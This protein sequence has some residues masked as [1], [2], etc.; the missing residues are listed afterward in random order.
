MTNYTEL[1]QRYLLMLVP[2]NGDEQQ[3]ITKTLQFTNSQREVMGI[4]FGKATPVP[5][6]IETNTAHNRT[7]QLGTT[8]IQVTTA[9]ATTNT[10][11]GSNP[12][13]HPPFSTRHQQSP[14]G[15]PSFLLSNI[16][17]FGNSEDKDKTTELQATL[18][19][20]NINIAC[21]TETWLTGT[22]KNKSHW[23]NTLIF[24]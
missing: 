18:D 1:Y 11:I 2:V 10:P 17:S 21:L 12:Y 5:T 6:I 4:N 20:N 9:G 15:L 7:G 14:I 24:Q 8:T 3:I 16:Q 23:T 22:T 13:I 19:F